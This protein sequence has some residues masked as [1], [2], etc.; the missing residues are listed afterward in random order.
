[1]S[2][3]RADH[4]A[5]RPRSTHDN[6]HTDA[7]PQDAARPSRGGAH[8]S[9]RSTSGT[10]RPARL[11]IAPVLSVPA[12][13]GATV[14][15]LAAAGA[16][17][18]SAS[19]ADPAATKAPRLSDAPV[20]SSVEAARPASAATSSATR[21]RLLAGRERVASRDTARQARVDATSRRLKAVAERRADERSAALAR[22]ATL[23]EQRAQRIA[24]NAW[25]LPVATGAYHLTSRFGECSSLWSSCHT[26]LDFAAPSGTPIRAAARGTITETESAGAYGNRTIETLEDGTQLWYC[27]QTGFDVE[28]GDRVAAGEVIGSVGST[29]NTT[30][31][32]LHF[33]VRP[34]G[35]SGTTD[36][37]DST[38]ASTT[39]QAG[40]G[41]ADSDSGEPVDPFTALTQHGLR[42]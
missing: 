11:W 3:H 13:A 27:H 34:A 41:S 33:E 37:T 4:S 28:P 20:L 5:P 42:P 19:H 39:E 18:L 35:A 36:A 17:T 16:L 14:L 24:R 8:A 22:I 15:T 38:T 26:G 23:A 30:G 6:P 25:Q 2:T 40:E 10:G 1:V 29:G 21:A 9:Q 32:H 7:T 12:F 31:P